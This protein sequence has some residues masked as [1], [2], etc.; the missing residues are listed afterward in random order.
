MAKISL[1]CEQCG[2]NIILDNSHEIG[3]CEHCFPSLLLNKIRLFKK[4]L[5]ILQNMCTDT[6]GKMSRNYLQMGIN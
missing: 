1:I 6:K 3:T 5:R 2:G 4:S